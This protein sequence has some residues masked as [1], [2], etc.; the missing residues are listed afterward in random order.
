MLPLYLFALILG[1]G[2][3]A[4]S[5]LGDVLG[6]AGSHELPIGPAVDSHAA[7]ADA[8]IFS[9]RGLIYGLFGLGAVGSVLTWMGSGPVLTAGAALFGGMVSAAMVTALFRWVRSGE[10]GDREGDEGYIGL[11]GRVTLPLGAHGAGMIAV[12]RGERRVTLRAL[13]HT[14]A[15]SAD[16]A[17]WKNVVIVEMDGGVALVSPVDEALGP[18]A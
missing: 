17:A 6:D 7:H 5:L 3:L 2:F 14:A 15:A 9:I 13:P 16:P 18:G 4:V 12:E 8:R 11:P 10:I 1:G